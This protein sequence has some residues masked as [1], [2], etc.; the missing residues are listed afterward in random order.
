ME[1]KHVSKFSKNSVWT[2]K[3]FLHILNNS[4]EGGEIRYA[5]MLIVVT[6]W[7][8]QEDSDLRFSMRVSWDQHLQEGEGNENGQRPSCSLSWLLRGDVDGD[9]PFR[10][11]WGGLTWPDIYILASISCWH[12]ALEGEWGQE[13]Q[14][15]LQGLTAEGQLKIAP[16][17]AEA[18][19]LSLKLVHVTE[20]WWIYPEYAL[21][22][23]LV[24]IWFQ[25]CSWLR[26][27]YWEN[28]LCV[29]LNFLI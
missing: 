11:D 17:T 5:V 12:G 27:Y 28:V 4:H 15:F 19:S 9:W 7:V 25:S 26:N 2:Y 10:R 6:C 16:R 14:G 21:F 29:Y 22:W 24:F 13:G 1:V 20:S 3:S 8:P 18:T 23:T